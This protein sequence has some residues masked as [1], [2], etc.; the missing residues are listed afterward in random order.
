MRARGGQNLETMAQ[1]AAEAT[2]SDLATRPAAANQ[3][4]R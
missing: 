1:R 2:K 3:S 4:H